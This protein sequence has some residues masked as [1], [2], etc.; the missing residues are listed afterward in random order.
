MS[1]DTVAPAARLSHN[2]PETWQARLGR[3]VR[4]A[5]PVFIVLIGLLV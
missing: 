5:A 4:S 2:L 1:A 3:S